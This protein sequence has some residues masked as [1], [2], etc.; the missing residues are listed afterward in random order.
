MRAFWK[1]YCCPGDVEVGAH[2]KK[3]EDARHVSLRALHREGAARLLGSVR[4]ANQDA[5]ARRVNVGHLCQVD[6]KRTLARGELL[7]KDVSQSRGVGDVDL[8]G[9]RH[10]AASLGGC[11]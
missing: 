8:A 3:R 4:R 2:A 7:V 1:R 9:D 6:C 10:A 5:Y 11:G